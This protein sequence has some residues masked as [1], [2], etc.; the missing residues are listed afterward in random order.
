MKRNRF[1]GRRIKKKEVHSVTGIRNGS[2]LKSLEDDPNQ[3]VLGGK[4]G[5]Y[6]QFSYR[7]NRTRSLGVI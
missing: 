5:M 6:S 3:R 1:A 2:L 4:E 7:S